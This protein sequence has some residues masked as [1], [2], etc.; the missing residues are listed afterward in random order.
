MRPRVPF[1]AAKVLHWKPSSFFLV[2]CSQ[3]CR[4]RCPAAGVGPRLWPSCGVLRCL[5]QRMTDVS[6][7]AIVGVLLSRWCVPVPLRQERRRQQ[8][9][10]RKIAQFFIPLVWILAPPPRI[11]LDPT[12]GAGYRTIGTTWSVAAHNSDD[13]STWRESSTSCDGQ[14][15]LRPGAI[16]SAVGHINYGVAVELRPDISIPGACEVN[17]PIDVRVQKGTM[18]CC[19]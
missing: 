13:L 17:L 4:A 5:R 2:F 19:V 7:G 16:Y 8:S 3:V 12:R 6:V 15:E 18:S 11:V 9:V 1:T 10:G 14:Q